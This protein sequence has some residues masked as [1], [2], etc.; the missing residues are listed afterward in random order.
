[1]RK[2]FMFCII[3]C[4]L[5]TFNVLV[6]SNDYPNRAIT[7][8]NP[9]A[10][11]G[12]TDI[13]TRML[14]PFLEKYLGVP[15]VVVNMPGAA[16]EVGQTMIDKAQPD[17]YTMGVYN[18]LN[19]ISIPLS[20]P[21]QYDWK[22][23][24]P[25]ANIAADPCC[26]VVRYDDERFPDMNS[27]ISLAKAQPGKLSMG[28]GGVGGDDYIV[29]MIFEDKAGIDFRNVSFEGAGPHILALLGGHIDIASI[30]VSEAMQYVKSEQFR[31]LVIADE[32]R[33]EE[34]PDVPTFREAGYDIVLVSPRG[35]G[36]PPGTPLEI[37]EILAEAFEKTFDDPDFIDRCKEINISM[38]LLNREEMI[39]MIENMEKLLIEAYEIAP[40]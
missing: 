11:G 12:G 31:I 18:A 9:W 26:L 29:D 16:G 2:Y 30:N 7:I 36:M 17:G 39:E 33:N 10:A 15:F 34:I 28:H 24:E 20:R 5:L 13:Q 27:L 4:L 14:M 1:M 37:V 35:Y 8:I 21:V 6:F 38:G 40:W 32:Q 23:W 25:L 19:V 22:K 3:M